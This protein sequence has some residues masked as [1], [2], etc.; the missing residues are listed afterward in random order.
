MGLMASDL[1]VVLMSETTID[2]G[3]VMIGVQGFPIEVNMSL[4]DVARKIK[5]AP[6]T[7]LAEL[8]ES[9]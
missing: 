6:L 7:A 5:D 2:E 9:S 4:T 8:V 3:E 1:E